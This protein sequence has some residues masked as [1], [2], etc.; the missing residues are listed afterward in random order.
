MNELERQLTEALKRLSAQSTTERRRQSEQAE[1]LHEQV[2]CLA[3]ASRAANRGERHLEA[4][5]R[6]ARRASGALDR[7]LRDI[8]RRETARPRLV[9]T[10]PRGP[11][12]D[13]GPSR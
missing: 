6:A 13:S 5:N 3:A 12:R 2:E 10:P 4:A 7:V 9:I 11:D 1:A 8:R